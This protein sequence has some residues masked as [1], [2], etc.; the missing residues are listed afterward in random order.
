MSDKK[1]YYEAEKGTFYYVKQTPK[2]IYIKWVE[3]KSCDG[4]LLDQNVMYKELV[5]NKD[6]SGKH[7]LKEND[8]DGILIYPDRNGQFF[9]LEPTT[10]KHIEK[11]IEDC[12]KWGVSY[13]YYQDLRKANK[14]NK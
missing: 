8:E 13:Q 3:H 11:E 9:Y 2:R 12:K 1:L 10:E 14:H 7:C 4:T 5:I 6:N